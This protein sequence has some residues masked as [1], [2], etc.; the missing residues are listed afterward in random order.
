[1]SGDFFIQQFEE[2]EEKLKERDKVQEEKVREIAA[3]THK[4]I[5]STVCIHH[6]K[7][8]CKKE[9]KCEFLHEYDPNKMPECKFYSQYGKCNNGVDCQFKHIDPSE[10]IRECPYYQKGF[11]KMGMYCKNNHSRKVICA[12]YTYGFCPEGPECP[13][14]HAK[15]LIGESDDNLMSISNIPIPRKLNIAPTPA[16]SVIC[17]KCGVPGHK[18]THCAAKPAEIQPLNLVKSD[19]YLKSVRGVLCYKCKQFGHYAN[20]CPLRIVK[21]QPDIYP[22]QFQPAAGMGQPQFLGA[23]Q[24]QFVGAQQPQF[25][26]AQQSQ[27]VGAPQSAQLS[28][29]TTISSSQTT[30]NPQPQNVIG[31]NP[32]GNNVAPRQQTI[33]NFMNFFQHPPT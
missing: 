24:P 5:Q 10:K 26:G 33:V 8:L 9:D 4:P 6:M 1:M 31:S 23:Q 19:V 30:L 12:N 3:K 11:C 17:H 25:M 29:Q 15:S 16:N 18:S 2:I 21:Q 20:M 28:S 13:Y 14:V 27:F 32:M 7:G 22:N